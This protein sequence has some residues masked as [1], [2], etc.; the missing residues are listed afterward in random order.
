MGADCKDGPTSEFCE[1]CGSSMCFACLDGQT[2]WMPW[3]KNG[4]KDI[5]GLF[6]LKG[7][8]REQLLKACPDWFKRKMPAGCVLDGELWGG[9]GQFQKTVWSSELGHES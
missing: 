8:Q 7:R 9:R 3:Q 1:I 5:F 2:L 6:L 4:L